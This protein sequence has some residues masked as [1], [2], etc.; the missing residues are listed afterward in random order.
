MFGIGTGTE[1][2]LFFLV[3]LVYLHLKHFYIQST[4]PN[5]YEIE[6]EFFQ[7]E[8]I[9]KVL[10]LRN[11]CLMYPPF[12]DPLIEWCTQH[13]LTDIQKRCPPD[14]PTFLLLEES[15]LLPELRKLDRLLVPPICVHSQYSLLTESTNWQHYRNERTYFIVSGEPASPLSIRLIMPKK[16]QYLTSQVDYEHFV[17]GAVETAETQK[18]VIQIELTA[19][20]IFA[21]PPFWWAQISFPPGEKIGIYRLEYRTFI[22]TLAIFPDL[23]QSFFQRQ[24]I[25]WKYGKVYQPPPPG[26][27]AQPKIFPKQIINAST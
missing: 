14:T 5:I 22:N 21:L 1:I 7:A 19:G 6:P 12:F 15:G 26:E 8:K 20:R 18:H 24:N 16:S 4:D 27:G 17:F 10:S 25:Q 3:C 2:L 13:N 9:E 11:P 23:I